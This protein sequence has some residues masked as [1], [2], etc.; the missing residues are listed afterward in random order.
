MV[1][2][3][4]KTLPAEEMLLRITQLQESIQSHRN[5]DRLLGTGRHPHLGT[6]RGLALP[7]ATTAT[8]ASG[9]A[10]RNILTASDAFLRG[11]AKGVE[12]S[13]DAS[14]ARLLERQIA[15]S[16][17]LNAVFPVVFAAG[18]VAG[19]IKDVVEGIKGIVQIV[20]NID[21]IAAATEKLLA[22][23]ARDSEIA[24]AF[25]VEVGK[26]CGR[27]LTKMSNQNAVVFTFE[28]GLLIGPLVLLTI[29]AI[30]GLPEALGARIIAGLLSILKKFPRLQSAV[31]TIGKL[32]MRLDDHQIDKALKSDNKL[33]TAPNRRL[34]PGSP[35]AMAQALVAELKR[36][37]KKVVV[38]IGGEASPAEIAAHGDLARHA[39]N[40][41]PVTVGRQSADQ[42]PNLLRHDAKE[43]GDLFDAGQVD[44]IISNRLPPNTLQWDKIIPGAKKTLRSGGTIEIRFQGTGRDGATIIK[45]LVDEGFTD[46]RIGD[47][48]ITKQQLRQL[49]KISQIQAKKP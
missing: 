24:H 8:A 6:P 5:V 39:I 3:W 30:L 41:N 11:V 31:R 7:Y 47:V 20:S 18:A 43:I 45:H 22:E 15:K 26:A 14:T 9:A 27:D 13:V 25:G 4:R 36:K 32:A 34:L 23:I 12:Q 28:L 35:K 10:I 38:N 33:L 16:S 2:G 48:P 37:N 17:I 1:S 42:I 44:S 21:K 40:L 19:I 49:P 29:L 46:F